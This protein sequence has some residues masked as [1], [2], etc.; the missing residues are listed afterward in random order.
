MQEINQL[1]ALIRDLSQPRM[2]ERQQRI[3]HIHFPLKCSYFV[4]ILTI[5]V[6]LNNNK[7]NH[8]DDAMTQ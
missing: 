5:F 1:H 2:I 6:C 8:S 3:N 7:H 4:T